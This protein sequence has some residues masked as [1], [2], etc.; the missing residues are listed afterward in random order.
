M[1]TAKVDSCLFVLYFPPV[2]Q[3]G[4]PFPYNLESVIDDWILL[5]FLVGNDFLPNLPNMHIKQVCVSSICR[6]YKYIILIFRY[7]KFY[8]ISRYY[9]YHLQL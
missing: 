7:Y 1:F 3:T 4:L 6:Y 8:L 2:P 9:K 5:G